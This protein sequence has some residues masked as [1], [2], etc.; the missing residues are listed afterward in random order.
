M[1]VSA[2]TP[3]GSPP[4]P[5]LNAVV[6]RTSG[7]P[8]GMGKASRVAAGL[9]AFPPHW[10]GL[11]SPLKWVIATIVGLAGAQKLN[12]VTACLNG[13]EGS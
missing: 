3:F 5:P 7:V 11:A 12:F 6:C 8:T 1:V 2:V 13:L 4:L 10:G 9:A